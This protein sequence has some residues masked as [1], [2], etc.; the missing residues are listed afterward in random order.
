MSARQEPKLAGY[1][2]NFPQALGFP[3]GSTASLA[4]GFGG[5]LFA[6]AIMTVANCLEVFVSGRF[7]LDY[8]RMLV[9]VFLKIR[10]NLAGFSCSGPI[11][12]PGGP[13]MKAMEA[14]L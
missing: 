3:L 9:L 8:A 7:Q 13:G 14:T 10:G 12:R 11:E 6:C 4:A 1:R 2:H 5:T